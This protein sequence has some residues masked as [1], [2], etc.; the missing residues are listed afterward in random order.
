[1]TPGDGFLSP[2]NCVS[3][4]TMAKAMFS[5]VLCAYSGAKYYR[6]MQCGQCSIYPRIHDQTEESW[7]ST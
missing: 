1:M 7:D 6:K 3:A 5:S 4:I 2:A